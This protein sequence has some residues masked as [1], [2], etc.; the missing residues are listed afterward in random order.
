MKRSDLVSLVEACRLERIPYSRAWRLIAVGTLPAVRRGSAWLVSP[1][2][3]RRV[4]ADV[5]PGRPAASKG[6]AAVV[7]K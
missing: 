7:A 6:R 1:I 5:R 3:L 4:A 2:E